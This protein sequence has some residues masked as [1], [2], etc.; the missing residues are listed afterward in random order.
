MRRTILLL[1][2]LVASLCFATAPAH[3][4][5]YFRIN[6]ARL[7]PDSQLSTQ[8]VEDLFHAFI[9]IH[10][11]QYQFDS[12]KALRFTIFKQNMD[13]VMAM[14]ANQNLT[15][16]GI[17]R[18]FDW[19][20][21]EFKRNRLTAPMTRPADAQVPEVVPIGDLPKSFEYALLII[22]HLQIVGVISML[23]PM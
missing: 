22:N 9:K 7:L 19:T 13:K 23:L 1:V 2:A 8:D 5:P 11:K 3:L 4:E 10:G 15:T 21:E 6:G 18:F 12:E 17:T 16:Y 14:N 20:P